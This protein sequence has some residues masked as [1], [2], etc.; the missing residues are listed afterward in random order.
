VYLILKV[1]E[2]F[3]ILASNGFSNDGFATVGGMP[4][5]VQDSVMDIQIS[6]EDSLERVLRARGRPGVILCDRGLMDG[7]SYMDTLDWEKLLESRDGMTS[8][9][10]REG[11]YNAVFHL[12]TAAEGA[13]RYYSKEGVRTESP[14]EARD[15]DALTRAAW[16]GH[17][18]FMVIDNSTD[19]E[20]KM[21]KLVNATARLLGL[22]STLNRTTLKYLLD[23]EPNLDFFPDDIKYHIF[24]VEKVY[25]HENKPPSS[26]VGCDDRGHNVDECNFIRKR[27]HVSQSEIVKGITY[28]L[29]TV[30]IV[31]GDQ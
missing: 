18:K 31:S 7:S 10:A 15:L 16:V 6:L 30:R 5:Y 2:A 1:L 11:R 14:A 27:S 26:D 8:S 25:L 17:P 29:T 23:S 4:R 12:V 20:G 28:G 19:F 13:E 9:D 3:T 24:D 21:R 22:P